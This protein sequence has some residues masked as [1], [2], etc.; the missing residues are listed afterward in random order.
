[1]PSLLES[2][3]CDRRYAQRPGLERTVA[4]NSL[5]RCKGERR[6]LCAAEPQRRHDVLAEE[7]TA[8]WPE[9]FAAT[10]P[11]GQVFDDLQVARQ[12]VAL[13]PLS[14]SRCALE[15]I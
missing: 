10:R 15:W 1:M 4:G 12:A 3:S 13:T 11:R 5:E 6:H 2:D 9:R 8:V 14:E 7:V